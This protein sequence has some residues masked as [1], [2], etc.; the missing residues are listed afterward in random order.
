MKVLKDRPGLASRACGA[1]AAIALAGLAA[2]A[3]SAAEGAPKD[4]LL[5][6][7]ASGSMWGQIDG[8]NKIVI[9][10]DVVE[11]LTFELPAQQRLG[12]VA[13][14]HRRK[15]DCKDIETLAEVGTDR[16]ALRRQIRS[17]TPRGMTPLSAAVQHAADKLDYTRQ[18]ATVILVSD[19]EE[20][21]DADPCALGRTLEENGLDF[22]VHVIGFDVT[23]EQRKGL[24]CL[25]AETG[26]QFLAADDAAQLA[27]A[28]STVAISTPPPEPPPAAPATV[29]LKA[30]ILDGGPL[31]Q[32][33]LDWSM[34]PADPAPP[35]DADGAFTGFEAGGVGVVETELPEG[36]YRLRAT[37]HG[38]K[39]GN[40]K[41]GQREVQV[42]AGK[43][44]VFTIPVDLALPVKLDAPATAH[45]GAV[46]NV[47]WHGPDDLSTMLLV[48]EPDAAPDDAIFFVSP[49]KVA[50]AEPLKRAPLQMPP[51][52]GRYELRYTLRQP[53]V[54]LA[55]QDIEITPQ[56][57]TLQAPERAS[58]ASPI[59]IVWD[60]P[61][62]EH[63]LVTIVPAGDTRDFDNARYSARL[64]SGTPVQLTTP[65][66]AG[67][68]EIRYV[69]GAAYTTYPGMQY[70]IKAT[71]P[72][73]V[74]DVSASVSGPATAE[75]GATISVTWTGPDGWDDDWIS[76]VPAGE[77]FNR[78]SYV[79]LKRGANA[80]PDSEQIRV[81]AIAGDYEIAYLVN[82]GRKVIAR[83]PIRIEASTARVEAPAT[84]KAGQEIPVRYRGA[85]F[86]GDRVVIAPADAPDG[87]MWG[88]T[89]NH[90]FAAKPAREADGEG[91]IP[92][93]RTAE[94]GQYEL[95]YVTGLQHQVLARTPV[96]ITP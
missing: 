29:V 27:D 38:W 64:V 65:G 26:G 91:K 56:N 6:L 68:Y 9:A 71:R 39:D 90:G 13:Y 34:T 43:T 81:P 73:R 96:E 21:C 22:T 48:T 85:G 18:A 8:V 80:A 36:R 1:L 30:T 33:K 62:S 69:M 15:S 84:I 17:L 86:A 35:T 14:G 41:Q 28:L 44:H 87:K 61:L 45:E 3:V 40:P 82:P 53:Q 78:D 12:L 10:K 31:I 77:G 52:A 11:A 95:R 5:V 25:A 93:R 59:D 54:V 32:S 57:F 74:E 92:A 75:G 47:G 2:Q 58:I 23:V 55:R 89:V 67:D 19:G 66:E 46:I 37:W 88:Y 70:A 20:T 49:S 94:P 51:R 79:A 42:S 72:L 7:D 83:T 63:D 60:G 16:E 4:S 24:Q 50:A 76:V